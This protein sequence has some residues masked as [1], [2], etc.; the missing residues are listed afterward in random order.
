MT[1]AR[2]FLPPSRKGNQGDQRSGGSFFT[3]D[4]TVDGGDSDA[5]V[6][7]SSLGGSMVSFSMDSGSNVH[8]IPY[9][10]HLL[11]RPSIDKKCPFGNKGQLHAAMSG[12][13]RPTVQDDRKAVEIV[14]RM[15]RGF[16]VVR[17]VF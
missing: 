6:V 4:D 17:P 5:M 15:F 8:M 16:R 3:F 7:S 12:V 14:S 9:L 1:P 11:E 2:D 10:D 13:I